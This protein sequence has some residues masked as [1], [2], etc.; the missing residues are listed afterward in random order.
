MEHSGIIKNQSLYTTV[1]HFE[2]FGATNIAIEDGLNQEILKVN[3]WLLSNKLVGLL[4]VAISKFMLFFKHPKIVPT[5]NLSINDNPV[6][7]VTS[8]NFLCITIDQ[9]ITWSDHILKISIKVA[10]VIGILS[11]LKHIFPHNIL[12][13]I[14]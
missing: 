8:F 6:E 12:R 4:N 10:R 2:N 11:K 1:S 13:T 5:L 14:I 7:Q 3:T 9:N